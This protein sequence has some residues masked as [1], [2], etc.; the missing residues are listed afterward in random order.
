MKMLAASQ[1]MASKFCHQPAPGAF[2][3]S[4]AAE[5]FQGRAGTSVE[6]EILVT[7]LYRIN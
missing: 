2:P 1:L 4:P 3:E 7:M 5:F 6:L